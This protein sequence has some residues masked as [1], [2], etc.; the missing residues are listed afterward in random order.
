MSWLTILAGG[1]VLL[2]TPV[3]KMAATNSLDWQSFFLPTSRL[4]ERQNLHQAELKQVTKP[5]T[6]E[7]SLVEPSRLEEV[8]DPSATV[9]CPT[10]IQALAQLM[11]EYLPGYI[12]RVRSRQ[13]V[14]SREAGIV[15]YTI[16][17]GRVELEPL[18]VSAI[19]YN[20]ISPQTPEQV[21]FTTLEREYTDNRI[22]TLQNYHWLFLTQTEAGWRLVLMYTRFGTP[23]DRPPLPPQESSET[24]VGQAVQLW[25][26]DCRAG[27][28][29]EVGR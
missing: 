11:V 8:L 5:Q 25:L 2:T 15:S 28:L 10:D 3:S 17:A 22:K 16:V 29:R 6:D 19:Q 23:T 13:Q 12:N 14:L 20:S 1:L 9:A 21:F 4:V 27:A 26:R 24:A 7:D 18:P